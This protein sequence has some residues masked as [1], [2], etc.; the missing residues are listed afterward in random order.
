MIDSLMVIVNQ[1]GGIDEE[2]KDI[3]KDYLNDIERKGL[4]EFLEELLECLE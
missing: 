2:T 3:L 4:K 1:N